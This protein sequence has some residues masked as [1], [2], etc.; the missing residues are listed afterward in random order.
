MSSMGSASVGVGMGTDCELTLLSKR[1]RQ[2]SSAAVDGPMTRRSRAASN[3]CLKKA[4]LI[5]DS[6]VRN[7]KHS[8]FFR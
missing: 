4:S 7:G 1:F 6:G 2:L 8:S 5:I 3:S